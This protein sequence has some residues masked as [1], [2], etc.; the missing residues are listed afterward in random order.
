MNRLLILGFALALTACGAATHDS[1]E[2]AQPA[3]AAPEADQ[4]PPPVAG[5]A[6]PGAEPGD[7]GMLSSSGAPTGAPAGAAVAVGGN[8]VAGAG[9]VFAIPEGWQR[10][11]PSSS[12]RMAQ[13]SIPGAGG[14]G[15]LTV[16]F[17]GPGGGGGVEANLDRWVGQIDGASQPTRETFETGGLKVTWIEVTGTL[18]PSGFGMGPS[19]PQPGS[20]LFGA[21]IEGPGGPWFFKATGPD[22][23]L[24]GQRDAF[25]A[26]L[27]GA[28]LTS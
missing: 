1:Q 26:M 24:S 15:T 17:F 7:F 27:R 5:S 25:L 13:A 10:E 28:R 19:E 11:A 22:E 14:D 18:M 8:E 23:T 16:F 20:R 12:M 9:L 21:V 2:G 6:G 3:V 4:A